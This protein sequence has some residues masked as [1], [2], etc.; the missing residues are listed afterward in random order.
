MKAFTLAEMLLIM[1]L[2]S[3]AAALSLPNL[4]KSFKTMQLENTVNTLS[5]SMRYAQSLAITQN[6][7]IRLAFEKS[8]KSYRLLEHSKDY[9]DNQFKPLPGRWS[10]LT[11]V[12]TGTMITSEHPSIDFLPNG[13]I[14]KN[15]IQ[16]CLKEDC[17]LISTHEQRGQI[18][19][20]DVT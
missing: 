16:I 11:Q 14:E 7:T 2:L 17:M 18:E 6:K 9:L 1:V 12:P 8:F 13:E 3:V 15:D 4:S 19:V 10:K 5:F 20:L